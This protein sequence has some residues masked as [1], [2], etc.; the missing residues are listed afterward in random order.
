MTDD[1]RIERLCKGLEEALD[2]MQGMLLGLAMLR[3]DRGAIKVAP[4]PEMTRLRELVRA[5]RARLAGA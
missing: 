5:E 1:E 3:N 2:L 4:S